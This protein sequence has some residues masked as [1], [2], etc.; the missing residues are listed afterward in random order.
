M[1]DTLFNWNL[2]CYQTASKNEKLFENV[3]A[4]MDECQGK[5]LYERIFS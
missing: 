1:N 4:T 3:T 2:F 5:I